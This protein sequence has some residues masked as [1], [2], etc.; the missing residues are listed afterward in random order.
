MEGELY[1]RL[2]EKITLQKTS[3]NVWNA[4]KKITPN[5]YF[6][7][8]LQGIETENQEECMKTVTVDDQIGDDSDC[9]YVIHDR[10]DVIFID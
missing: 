4:S 8:F 5:N 9:N 1:G 3:E 2:S 10:I 7:D 6:E